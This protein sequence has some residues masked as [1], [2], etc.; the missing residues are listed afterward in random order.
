MVLG[1]WLL[2]PAL[3]YVWVVKP[4]TADFA[5]ARERLLSER[6][7]LLRE[8]ALLATAPDLPA[9]IALADSAVAQAQSRLFPGSDPV[10][11][12]AALARYLTDRAAVHHVLVQGSEARDPTTRPSDRL[13]APLPDDLLLLTVE[14]RAI[15]DLSGITAWLAGLET[16][17]K[18][19][20][21]SEL[22]IIPAAR[23]GEDE[24]DEEVLGVFVRAT[25]LT[26]APV[27]DTGAIALG[28]S[29]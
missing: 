18:L 20:D 15:G 28:D 24:V 14:V 3:A 17:P 11:A 19:V 5:D 13:S 26:L 4:V 21:V 8:R 23:A 16:G 1:A 10:S 7:L 2:L 25:G 29:P 6:D 22:R 27:A 9:S 12:T